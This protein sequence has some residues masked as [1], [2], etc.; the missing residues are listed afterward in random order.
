MIAVR[1]MLLAVL[2]LLGLALT[3][4]A[5]AHEVRPALLQVNETVPGQ[6]ELLWKQ[7]TMGEVAVRLVPH[8]SSG[9]LEA[10]PA[11]QYAA[12][13]FLIKTWRVISK[14]P[15]DGQ[16]LSIEGLDRT[17]TD[18]LVRVTLADGKRL[19]KVVKPNQSTLA[20]NLSS[21][22]G[23]AAPAYL[24][25]G[26]E[27]IL[28]G[29][30]HLLFVLGLL[31][32]GLG[33]RIVKTVTA[34]TVAHSITLSLAALG[35]VRLPSAVIEALVALSIVFVAAE[36]LRS[37]DRPRTLTPRHPWIIAF[38]FGL[39]HGLAFAGALADIGLPVGAV[40]M[41]LLL[42]NVGVEIGQLMFIAAALAVILLLRWARARARAPLDLAPLA[43]LGPAYGIGAF[44][45]FWFF[46]RLAIAFTRA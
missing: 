20:L 31:L 14:T 29:F 2:A 21:G 10:A 1:A 5:A 11:D 33:W 15:L 39:L 42:F 26:V 25:L 41:A 17:I 44:A 4:P 45:M 9:W 32:L 40:P 43:R 12:P 37:P 19:D 7:P 3:Q 38:T 27:H 24:K 23:P 30:D 18:V 46:E 13:G 22:Q 6:Y 36:L 28:T 8:L 35:F 34:F 16:T